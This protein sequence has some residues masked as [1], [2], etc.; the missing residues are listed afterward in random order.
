MSDARST[1]ARS[2]AT[3]RRARRS[4]PPAPRRPAPGRRPRQAESARLLG[5]LQRAVDREPALV[6]VVGDQAVVG[7]DRHPQRP[8]A[9]RDRRSPGRASATTA[10]GGD[11]TATR[12]PGHAAWRHLRWCDSRVHDL[13][14][15]KVDFSRRTLRLVVERLDD[16]LDRSACLAPRLRPAPAGAAECSRD[17]EASTSTGCSSP[18]TSIPGSPVAV[19]R[20]CALPLRGVH[21]QQAVD[22]LDHAG[23]RFARER[24][25]I[26]YHVDL[27]RILERQ[28]K[29]G[30]DGHGQQICRRRPAC[31][32]RSARRSIADV[33]RPFSRTLDDA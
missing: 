29:P 2:R 24:A 28:R 25:A 15:M 31:A 14:R 5:T 21:D 17:D 10:S 30:G 4:A 7:L 23:R 27:E 16:D 22:V 3:P 12:R 1:A 6:I 20:K 9:G 32:G 13:G 33:D 18:A 8:E 19:T 26:P 11:T